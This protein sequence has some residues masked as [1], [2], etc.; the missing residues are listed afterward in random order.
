MS[1]QPLIQWHS[2]QLADFDALTVLQ[3]FGLRQAVFILEQQCLY[4]DIDDHDASAI[5]LLGMDSENQLM[6]YLRILA[7]GTHYKEPAIGRVVVAQSWRGTGIG[8]L[9]I[10]EGLRLVVQ[11]FGRA[12]IRISAQSHLLK[13]YEDAGFEVVGEEYL[14]DGIPHLEML[15]S[16]DA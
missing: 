6:A 4:S 11:H 10:D 12:D 15:L 2:G 14:D 16:A 7:P 13:L 3:M 8:G 1:A 5:H 9:L